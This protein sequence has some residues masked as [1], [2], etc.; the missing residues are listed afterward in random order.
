[1]SAGKGEVRWNAATQKWE[2]V[3]GSEPA[4][5]APPGPPAPPT[6]PAPEPPPEEPHAE[7]PGARPARRVPVAVV[8][9][10]VVV[11]AAGAGGG[12]LLARGGSDHPKVVVGPP[13][14]GSPSVTPERS[15]DGK[16]SPSASS[17]ASASPG[18]TAPAGF[19][20][21]QDPRGFTLYVPQGWTR[22]DQGVKGVFYNS[23]DHARLIQVYPVAETGLSPYDALKQTSGELAKNPG[24]QEISLGNDATVPGGATQAARLVYAYDN[25][26]LGHRRQ[27]V[28]YAFLTPGGEHYAVLSAAPAEAWPEQEQTLKAALSAFCS[29]SN[30][31]SAQ[32][33]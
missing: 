8:V 29:G 32:A 9:A 26:Q 20:L 18:S 6:P 28:D 15:D 25:Q 24:Y 7:P 19:Q 12:W 33:G 10:M 11:A 5:P 22:E 16:G 17:S 23:A 1:M 13:A 21:V 31:R 30:C 4:P 27:V 2:T 3:Q 14:S